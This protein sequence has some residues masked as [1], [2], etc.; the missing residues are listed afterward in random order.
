MRLLKMG[1]KCMLHTFIQ[2]TSNDIVLFITLIQFIECSRWNKIA[3]FLNQF[4]VHLIFA[5]CT[6]HSATGWSICST[7]E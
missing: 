1:M 2:L 5:L 4:K 6:V 3:L 7:K